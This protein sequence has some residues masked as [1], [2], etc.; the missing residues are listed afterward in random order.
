[1]RNV[2]SVYQKL[3]EVKHVHQVKLYKKFLRRAPENCKYNYEYAFG[4]KATVRLC[5]LHQ[6]DVDLKN[7][8]FPNLIDI[9]QDMQKCTACDA[10][11][12]RYSKEDLKEIFNKGLENKKFK[13]KNFPD[14][15][16]LEWVLEQSVVGI[17]PLNYIERFWFFIKKILS[18]KML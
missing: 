7:S 8:I 1:M 16:A 13:E 18:K 11:I 17:P 14:L 2:R 9:C 4:G 5:L 3:K 12:F 10:F 6:P 15:C